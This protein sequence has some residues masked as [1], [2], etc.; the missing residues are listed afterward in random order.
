[1]IQNT[2]EI[3][4]AVLSL[5]VLLRSL[6]PLARL[7]RD[8]DIRASTLAL[9]A[10]II[11]GVVG[12]MEILRGTSV[13]KL[14]YAAF[15]V[16]LMLFS[17]ARRRRQMAPPA[18]LAPVLLI[19]L[20][21]AWLFGVNIVQNEF[22]TGVGELLM[23]FAPGA[24]WLIFLFSWK[25]SPVTREQLSP[26]AMIAVSIPGLMTPFI[27]DAWRACD[28]Y[29]CGVFDGMLKGPYISENYLSQQVVVALLLWLFTYGLRK[30][31]LPLLLSIAWLLATESR[32]SQYTLLVALGLALIISMVDR[33]RDGAPGI[34]GRLTLTA[35]ALTFFVIAF[36]LAMTALPTDFSGRGRIW[37][38][39]LEAVSEN[40]IG[41]LGV[42]R[43]AYLQSSGLVS[44]LYQHSLYIFVYFG[45][46][47]IG[48]ILLFLWVRQS[49]VST[50]MFEKRLAPAAAFGTAFLMLG[51]LEVVS[52]PMALD[53]TLWIALS[54][55]AVPNGIL[56]GSTKNNRQTTKF[57]DQSEHSESSEE[58][59]LR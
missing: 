7:L 16:L 58:T 57:S 33:R 29:K 39:A 55:F 42:D 4:I 17:L 24:I 41:G 48:L 32:T 44:Q 20:V 13:F 18:S 6:P 52:N 53:G 54:L 10:L 26:L 36:R 43:W 34:V 40:S 3:V 12:D 47:V 1:M 35:L 15:F 9:A 49:L 59:T 50:A 19:T 5:L 22:F 23:R 11:G 38:R 25:H 8:P 45:G 28:E 21:W 27:S 56:T 51:L 46:G 2:A 30:S 37:S 31:L 14:A